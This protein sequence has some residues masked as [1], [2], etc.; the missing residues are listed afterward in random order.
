MIGAFAVLAENKTE[1]INI[2]SSDCEECKEYIEK[3][4]SD[5]EGV[6]LAHWDVET[7]KL[8]VNFDDS[9]TSSTD[10]EKALAKGGINT[11]NVKAEEEDLKKVSTCCKEEKAEEKSEM[12]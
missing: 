4:A 5:L 9:K 2:K 8:K 7:Q 3:I 12:K 11:P 1:E 10:I 6:T